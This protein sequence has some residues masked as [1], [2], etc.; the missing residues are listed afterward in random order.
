[1]KSIK[2]ISPVLILLCLPGPVLLWGMRG[3]IAEAIAEKNIWLIIGSVTMLPGIYYLILFFVWRGIIGV[4]GYKRM[5]RRL[6]NENFHVDCKLTDPGTSISLWIDEE[7]GKIAILTKRNPFSG[8]IV[9][10]GIITDLEIEDKGTEM[11]LRKLRLKFKAD[12]EPI[13]IILFNSPERTALRSSQ[14]AQKA[15]YTATSLQRSIQ[16]AIQK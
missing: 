4:L 2:K 11:V 10:A 5:E 9:S 3:F 15:L 7:K 1:M 13:T 6:S 16:N 14:M 8:Q 12:G